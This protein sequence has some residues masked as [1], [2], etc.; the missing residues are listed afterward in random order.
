MPLRM[1]S[2][3]LAFGLICLTLGLAAPA[4][5]QTPFTLEW[6]TKMKFG[7]VA[8]DEAAGGTI[9]LSP[10]ADTTTITG[11][12][13]DFGGTIKRGKLRITG[14]NSKAF[15]I[16]SWPSSFTIRKGTSTHVMT[17]SNITMNLTNPVKLSNSG[18]KTI[19]FGATLTIGADQK[20]GTY[21]DEGGFTIDVN[22]L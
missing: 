22:Y 15:V 14:G 7:T 21:N 1:I 3:V 11:S 20:K 10:A 18:A 12:L 2:V 19:F 4:Q 16:V 8:S 13:T 5:A 9:V 6:K 17:V